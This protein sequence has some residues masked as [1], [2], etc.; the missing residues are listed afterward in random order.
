MCEI[1]GLQVFEDRW[2]KD[3]AAMSGGWFSPSEQ[4]V[5]AGML[6]GRINCPRT[7]SMGRLFD[8][9]AALCGLGEETTF[10]GQAA[11]K[12]EFAADALG[13]VPP[14]R[15]SYRIPLQASKS[16]L[17]ADSAPMV[18]QA[19]ADRLKGTSAVQVSARFH[20]ALADLALEIAAECRSGKNY[21]YRGVLPERP[22]DG[23]GP[24]TSTGRGF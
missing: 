23:T 15:E 21:T 2:A 13:P 24:R 9:M 5:L 4:R 20:N 12:L 16:G 7:S 19:V 17:V 3:L 1:L 10:E 8:A 14:A 22:V 11:M 18:R 6:G